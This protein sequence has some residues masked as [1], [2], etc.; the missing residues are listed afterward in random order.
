MAGHL[1]MESSVHMGR[2]DRVSNR[3]ASMEKFS[4]FAMGKQKV[5]ALPRSMVACRIRRRSSL[6]TEMPARSA[7]PR[8]TR[9]FIVRGRDLAGRQHRTALPSS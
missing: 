9:C 3:P 6:R 5:I 4:V 7:A 2:A 8:A 1:V